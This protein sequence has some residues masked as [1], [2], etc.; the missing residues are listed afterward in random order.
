MLEVLDLAFL[1]GVR[2]S[3]A[4][5]HVKL[6]IDLQLFEAKVLVESRLALL[7]YREFRDVLLVELRV[8]TE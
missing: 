5:I 6:F 3:D 8:H 4:R 1:Y 7:D 2:L